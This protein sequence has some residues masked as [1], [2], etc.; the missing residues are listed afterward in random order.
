MLPA[1]ADSLLLFWAH[2][3]DKMGRVVVGG[4]VVYVGT[5]RHQS[6][7]SFSLDLPHSS[8]SRPIVSESLDPQF[9]LA[10]IEQTLTTPGRLTPRSP[11]LLADS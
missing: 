4:A 3:A 11:K 9:G 2:F 5:A 7:P 8:S 6:A 10:I 1:V